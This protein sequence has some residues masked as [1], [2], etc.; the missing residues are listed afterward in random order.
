[1]L[2]FFSSLGVVFY[3]KNFIKQTKRATA[4]GF[5]KY[6][7]LGLSFDEGKESHEVG[8][9][10]PCATPEPSI[11]PKENTFL[12][13]CEESVLDEVEVSADAAVAFKVPRSVEFQIPTASFESLN[14][15]YGDDTYDDDDNDG[16][17]ENYTNKGLINF[18]SQDVVVGSNAFL[19]NL[20]KK[21]KAQA[22][23]VT[24]I[25][26]NIERSKK[27]ASAIHIEVPIYAYQRTKLS[28]AAC[29]NST[30]A[31]QNS[32]EV[33]QNLT[34]TNQNAQEKAGRDKCD[35][36]KGARSLKKEGGKSFDHDSFLD[37]CWF[38]FP[39]VTPSKASDNDVCQNRADRPR[40]NSAGN[41]KT[42]VAS[43]RA[44]W[45]GVRRNHQS[46]PSLNKSYAL[47]GKTIA[48]LSSQELSQSRVRQ[49]PASRYV[50]PEV[51]PCD[52]PTLD[53]KCDK[54]SIHSG[55]GREE[56]VTALKNKKVFGFFPHGV[57]FVGN[58]S[59]PPFWG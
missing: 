44:Q 18:I 54:K 50:G 1:M 19:S 52:V 29:Q 8:I 58:Y 21:Q 53:L 47:Q 56:N 23:A 51:L 59:S 4:E 24:K 45:T 26:E 57:Q 20:K 38:E 11:K 30:A 25:N 2:L 12:G 14:D 55:K 17:D 5:K 31:C 9:H 27:K 10:A 6:S 33:N 15:S 40:V 16:D 41:A 36:V 7:A 37:H 32:T 49:A 48:F 39:S 34:D 13:V 46:G 22:R 35:S 43:G 3:D 28:T 42:C